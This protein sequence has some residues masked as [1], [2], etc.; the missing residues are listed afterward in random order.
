[1]GR[2]QLSWLDEWKVRQGV[3]AGRPAPASIGWGTLGGFLSTMQA[4]Y[5]FQSIKATGA[6]CAPRHR[7]LGEHSLVAAAIKQVRHEVGS[8]RGV[9]NYADDDP[10]DGGGA[11]YT[12]EDLQI[13]AK[14]LLD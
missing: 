9:D 8:R 3:G 4:L 13:I 7:R 11:D 10:Q 14:F 6:G 2:R 12:I 5:A 1:V